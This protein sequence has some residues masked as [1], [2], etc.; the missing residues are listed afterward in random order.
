MRNWFRKDDDLRWQFGL[1]PRGNANV[2]WV[3]HFIY[4]LAPHR[5]AGF[6]LPNGSMSS[7]LISHSKEMPPNLEAKAQ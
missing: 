1:P 4:H 7:K 3:Q 5:M 2:A 6:I